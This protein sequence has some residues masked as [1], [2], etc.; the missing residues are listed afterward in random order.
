MNTNIS[1]TV[2]AVLFFVASVAAVAAQ[3][4]R[5]ELTPNPLIRIIRFEDQRNWNEELNQFLRNANPAIRKRAAL[6]AGRIGDERAVPPLADM[7]LTDRDTDVRQ[8]AAF[9]LG[10]IESTGGAF[11]LTEVLK[12][13]G[14]DIADANIRAR[15]VE[16]LG[17]IAAAAA[18]TGSPALANPESPEGERL[19]I[20]K[21]A[22][23]DTLRFEQSRR[24]KP[25]K[26][27]ILLALT[28]VLR[29]KPEGAGVGPMVA[30]FLDDSDPE[31]VATALN[32]MARLRMKNANEQVRQ[33]LNHSDPIVR[34][35]AARVIGTAEHKEAFDALLDRA[36]KDPDIRVRASAIRALASLKDQRAG[37]PLLERGILLSRAAGLDDSNSTSQADV[38]IRECDNFLAKY[39][40]C[41][42]SKVPERA[43]H[44]YE[45]ALN[46]WRESWKKLANNPL[47]RGTLT[48]ACKQ[49]AEQQQ[50]SLKSYGCAVDVN[51][52]LEIVTTTGNLLR[53]SRSAVAIQWLRRLRASHP[54]PEVELAMARIDPE[55]YVTEEVK[56]GVGH[57][58]NLARGLQEI[59][60]I[61]KD[62][63]ALNRSTEFLPSW[64]RSLM[65]CDFSKGRGG[66]AN[67]R[68]KCL[69]RAIDV[70]PLLEAYAAFKPGDLESV[71][72]QE[73]ENSDV[74]VR[75]TAAELLGNQTP[76]ESNSRALIN[77]LPRALKDRDLND[78]ALAILDALGKQKTPAA[79]DAIKT[80]L[81][82]ND[83]L[84]R[85]KAVALLKANG[86]GDFSDRIGLVK[87][88]NT[89]IDYRR[90]VARIGKRSTATVIT[91]RGSF[92]IEF[93]TA[94]APLNVDNFIQLAKRGYFNGQTIPRVVPNF[95]VQA[96]DPR[97]DQNG[98]PGYQ[99]RCEINEIP[100][101]RAA[102]GMALSGKD[103][104]GSQWFVTHSPQPHLD[105]GYTVFGRV[106]RGMDVIDRIARGD[107]I[108]RVVV[109][110]R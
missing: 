72:R 9:A 107:S 90:A 83:H 26:L 73:L 95:V 96:G 82:S 62:H 16:A 53:D 74:I 4:A 34:A 39:D 64:M 10:E 41:V 70:S 24:P 101:E 14:A 86:V 109:S 75:S 65:L 6:A 15:A 78:A 56:F 30:K 108:R 7:L 37:Q 102:V 19:D 68:G 17:K 69:L 81:N 103:T 55:L 33:L 49:A 58:A 25:D 60:V 18:A 84:I 80:A 93:L 35:N 92:T 88:R 46:R 43:R 91:N 106:I 98:G 22:I 63:P 36:L 99:I 45:S 13:Q 87:T 48:T 23:L 44:E 89:D 104:G 12:P 71:L 2:F 100:Y 77:A 50:S 105:G 20:I 28:A 38:G 42:S 66:R 8:M 79:N 97:G 40:V 85:R 94:D 47:T 31:I 21:A 11:A 1:R 110:E 61:K 27:T 5:A 76:S 32:T 52:I 51:E 67:S 57:P 59:A 54:A 3:P 29:A